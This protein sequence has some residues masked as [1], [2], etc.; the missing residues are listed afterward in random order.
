MKT[1][2]AFSLFVCY[3]CC[4]LVLKVPKNYEDGKTVLSLK[5]EMNIPI[6]ITFCIRFKLQDHLS[7]LYIFASQNNGLALRFYPLESGGKPGGSGAGF[8]T[9][10]GIQIVFEIPHG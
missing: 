5:K 10:K 3:C 8:V 1:V 9:L 2:V 6:P 7:P 4:T